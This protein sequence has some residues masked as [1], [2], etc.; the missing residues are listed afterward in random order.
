MRTALCVVACLFGLSCET[1]ALPR[2]SNG[3][4]LDASLYTR[5]YCEDCDDA[6]IFLLRQSIPF[7]E[8]DVDDPIVAEHLNHGPGY[9]SLPVLY[10]C[11]RWIA[12]FGNQQ[13]AQIFE[14]LVQ[15]VRFD[16]ETAV[17]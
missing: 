8:L 11:G 15:P 1:E 9:S 17:R 12:G 6:R 2:C 16:R 5:R 14:L 7:L 13:R 3:H 4:L 10:M